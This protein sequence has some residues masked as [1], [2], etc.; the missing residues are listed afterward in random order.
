MN[1]KT[2]LVR[3]VMHERHLELDGSATIKQALDAMKES[4]AEVVIVKK[5]HPHDAIGIL[6]LSDIVKKVLAKDKAPER[7]NVY[8]IMSKPV[9]PVE[10]E[11]DV[12]YCARLFS[13]FGLSNAPVV[14]DG[15]VL[16]IVSYN[17]L[18]FDGLCELID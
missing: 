11:L 14:V 2:I 1:K 9:I 7:V 18:V 12:R 10:P 4:K 3:D 16:G 6:L 15:K 8:E 13:R 17:E 5:R